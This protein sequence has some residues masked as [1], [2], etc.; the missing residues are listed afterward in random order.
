MFLT[1]ST[2]ATA[3]E[4]LAD[5]LDRYTPAQHPDGHHNT[6]FLATPEGRTIGAR[7]TADGATLQLWITA[8]GTR[9]GSPGYGKPGPLR[10]GHSYHAVLKLGGLDGDPAEII[11]DTLARDLL[12]VFDNK[13]HYLGHRPWETTDSTTEGADDQRQSTGADL[14]AEPNPATA[15]TGPAAAPARPEQ[16]ASP[17]GAAEPGPEAKPAR[18]SR[19]RTAPKADAAPAPA[20]AKKAT[21]RTAKATPAKTAAKPRARKTAT[22]ATTKS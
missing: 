18:T 2:L 5:R 16:P 22:Q 1:A 14:A 8:P 15:N 10:P 20:S 17:K 7:V 21:A 11:H 9:S 4:H 19:K 6:Q 13:P 3:F 12:P